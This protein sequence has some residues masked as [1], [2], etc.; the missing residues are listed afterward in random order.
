MGKMRYLGIDRKGW[1]SV[2][3]DRGWLWLGNWT[4]YLYLIGSKADKTN[5]D[6]GG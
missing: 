1:E 2:P 5:I 3:S 4:V 6:I